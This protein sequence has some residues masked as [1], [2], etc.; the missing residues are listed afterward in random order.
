MAV[1]D[2]FRA[3]D[4]IDREIVALLQDQGRITITE[5]ADRVQL[6]V[7][8]CQR[9]VRTLEDDGVLRGYRAVAD[10]TALGLGF[11]VLV[12]A[13][14]DRPGAVE[15]FDAAIADVP[16]IIE[17]QRLFGEPDYLIRVVS[18]DLAAY[19]KL[20]ESTLVQLPGVTGLNSTIV[21]KHSV[22]LRPYP[23]R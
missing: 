11:E 19:Q 8:R 3:V 6:S 4:A 20:Y 21:M 15:A 14:L 12:F 23:V 22:P 16:Q 13:A 9:R 17:A 5:L 1:G 7:S 18:A 10:P 2:R